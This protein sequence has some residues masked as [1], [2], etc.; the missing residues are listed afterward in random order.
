MYFGSF[1]LQPDLAFLSNISEGR[2]E[3]RQY[4]GEGGTAGNSQVGPELQQFEDQSI[5]LELQSTKIDLSSN[6]CN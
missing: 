5:F 2:A 3:A 4:G 6:H 1:F